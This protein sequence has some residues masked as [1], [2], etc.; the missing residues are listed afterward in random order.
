MCDK[1]DQ[2]EK[3]NAPDKNERMARCIAEKV[4]AAGGR[5]FYVGGLVRDRICGR[6]TKDIDIE[7][8]GILPETLRSIL[9]T[10][11]NVTT[12]GLS[13]GILG[14]Q[15]YDIDIAM[16][17]KENATGRGHKDFEVF[18]DPFLGP[19]KA[20]LRRDFTINAMMEDVLTGEILDFYGGQED[21]RQGIVRHVNDVTFAEDPLRVL[22]AAQFAARFGYRIADETVELAKTMDLSALPRERIF[23][24]MEKAFLKAG[25]PSVFFE[26][27]RTMQQL[28]VW[29][30]ELE[31]LIGIPQD[32][33]H[34]PEGDVWIHSMMVLDE[35]AG[36]K[37][38][39]SDPVAFLTA[40]LIHDFGK[41]RTTQ[42]ADENGT[43]AHVPS[44]PVIHAYRHETEGLPEVSRFVKRLSTENY[45]CR[46]VLNM[47]CLHMRPNQS[48]YQNSSVK[49]TMRMFDESICPE[50]LLLLAK[51]DWLGRK[52]PPPYEEAEAFLKERLAIYHEIMKKPFVQGRDLVEA[53][54]RPGPEFKEALEYAH[55]LRLANVPKEAALRQTLAFLRDQNNAG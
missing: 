14:L 33:R 23:G 18:V 13:F 43:P 51:A 30:P 36:L 47:T 35:A 26:Q 27:L 20:A 44:V 22:R 7:V 21:I 52:D 31:E 37:D 55:K 41:A 16:P 39:A 32:A 5:T 49:A 2:I 1:Y 10:F 11:G 34:H 40:A 8:H 12:M 29:F 6:P 15:H 38:S 48:F 54:I 3:N 45:L 42:T 24:E 28:K 50:D 46:Y 19:E 4:D 53:G 9:E 17:R 25:K